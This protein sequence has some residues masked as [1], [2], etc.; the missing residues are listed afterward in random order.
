MCLFLLSCCL[1]TSGFFE[2]A[3]RFFIWVAAGETGIIEFRHLSVY[4]IRRF[5]VE[6]TSGETW[7]Y[8]I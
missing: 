8:R 7:Y 2:L 3:G 6:V 1:T 4:L 5:F